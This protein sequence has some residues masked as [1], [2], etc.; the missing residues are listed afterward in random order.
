MIGYRYGLDESNAVW[1]VK[2]SAPHEEVECHREPGFYFSENCIC[3]SITNANTGEETD[4]LSL[5]GELHRPIQYRK[6]ETLPGKT[7][8]VHSVDM[9]FSS[10]PA[11]NLLLKDKQGKIYKGKIAYRKMD[12]FITE[13]GQ[14]TLEEISKE[15]HITMA[16][17]LQKIEYLKEGHADED[18]IA[19]P[20]IDASNA[21]HSRKV[22]SGEIIP[23]WKK[24]LMAKGIDC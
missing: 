22:D 6:G 1:I 3:L 16:E 14:C 21:I 18:E 15:L 23:G 2:L 8:Y 7:W 17:L 24:F 11:M 5:T 13:C 9:L 20:L 19:K 4:T 10:D 12:E